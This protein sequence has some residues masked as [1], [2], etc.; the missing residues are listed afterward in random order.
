M[1]TETLFKEIVGCGLTMQ[2]IGGNLHIWPHYLITD[3]I[4]QSVRMM[5]ESLIGFIEAYE[6]RAAIMEFDGGM[7]RNDAEKNA[8]TDIAKLAKISKGTDHV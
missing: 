5:K 8:Y 7:D 1:E 6:E 2:A 3:H 4:R